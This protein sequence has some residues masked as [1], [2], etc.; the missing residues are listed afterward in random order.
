MGDDERLQMG[1]NADWM[2]RL[3]EEL[4][5]VPLWNLAIPGISVCNHKITVYSCGVSPLSV[6][7]FCAHELA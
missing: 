7:L 5:D 6:L 4:L 3:P 2:S 1:G